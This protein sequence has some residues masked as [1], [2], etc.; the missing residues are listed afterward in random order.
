[1]KSEINLIEKLAELEHEQWSHWTKHFLSNI[2]PE[3]KKRWKKQ[4]TIKYHQL[5]EKEKESDRKWARKVLEILEETQ[6]D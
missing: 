3:N 1:M 4:M 5:S 6:W 2:N